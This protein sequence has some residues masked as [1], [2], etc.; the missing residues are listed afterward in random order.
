MLLM[1]VSILALVLGGCGDKKASENASS[2]KEEQVIN[3]GY[4]KFGTL[5][6]FK[7]YR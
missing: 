3:I 2:S 5:N 1:M 6:Y 7:V 4:Q